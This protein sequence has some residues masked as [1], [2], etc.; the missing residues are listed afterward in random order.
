MNNFIRDIN[1]LYKHSICYGDTDSM[2]IGM[3]YWSV[4]DKAKLVGKELRQ[5]KNDYK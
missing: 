5:S 4:L 3:R 2:F 1:G